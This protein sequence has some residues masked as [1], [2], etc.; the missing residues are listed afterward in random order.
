MSDRVGRLN[1]IAGT[2]VAFG[3]AVSVL[4]YVH[5]N[6]SLFFICVVVIAFC[7]GGNITIFPAI[8]ADFFGLKNQTKNNG[9]IYQGFG[10]EALIGSLLSFG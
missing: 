10:L 9:I 1:I 5:L 8:A 3:I 7:F 6:E 2:L 4:N